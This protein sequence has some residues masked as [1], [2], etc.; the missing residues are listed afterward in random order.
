MTTI[1]TKLVEKLGALKLEYIRMPIR[2]IT[3]SIMITFYFCISL[4]F[5][6]NAEADILDLTSRNH[7]LTGEYS[8]L[9]VPRF[10]SLRSDVSNMRTGPGLRYPIDWIYKRSSLPVKIIREFSNYYLVVDPYGTQGWMNQAV[11][12]SRRTFIIVGRR[13]FL[14]D[15]ASHSGNQIADLRKGAIGN[16]IDCNHNSSW[17]NVRINSYSG[18]VQKIMMWGVGE[19]DLVE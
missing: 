8:K 7:I 16:I 6:H 18:W 11:I 10:A 5:A 17:C 19:D 13:T 4:Y 2:H 9:P 12:S 15:I 14:R 1:V 3:H